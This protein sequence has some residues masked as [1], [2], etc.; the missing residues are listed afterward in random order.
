MLKYRMARLKAFRLIRVWAYALVLASPLPGC[1][2]M[3]SLPSGEPPLQAPDG[4]VVE[5]VDLSVRLT[6]NPVPGASTYLVSWDEGSTATPGSA[7]HATTT[8]TSYLLTGLASEQTYAYVIQAANGR[9]DAGYPSSVVTATPST[10]LPGAPQRVQATAG[11]GLVTL[12]WEPVAGALTYRVS[13]SSKDGNQTL[14]DVALPKALHTSLRNG[15][16]YSYTVRAINGIDRNGVDRVG[17]PSDPVDAK[18]M[19]TQPGVPVI[20]D[21]TVGLENGAAGLSSPFVDLSWTAVDYASEYRVYAKKGLTGTEESLTLRDVPFKA[22]RYTHRGPEIGSMYFY[23]VEAVNDGVPGGRSEEVRAT[24]LPSPLPGAPFPTGLAVEPVGTTSPL[25][26]TALS[27]SA[28]NDIVVC[29][30][31]VSAADSGYRVSWQWQPAPCGPISSGS[32]TV[33][34]N[35][36]LQTGTIQDA[37]YTYTV[38]VNGSAGGTAP[39]VLLGPLAPRTVSAAPSSGGGAV[40]LEWTTSTSTTV[41]EQR[42][43]RGSSAAGPCTLV[44]SFAGNSSTTY[45]D[46]S[47]STGTT[48]YYVLRAFDGTR[49]SMDSDQLSATP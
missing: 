9:G 3:D 38:Q 45:T 33:A 23:S 7:H 26:P 49:E 18:P 10:A 30:S 4:V 36:Y 40:D 11:D 16:T 2:N 14:K 21:V 24:P 46:T 28:T 25:C 32:D 31:P 6:W 37:S 22:T 19:P 43:Y 39:N 17:P 20:I 8:N 47:V 15:V 13:V 5:I 27:G 12:Q 29:W 34:T 42:L 44:T 35:S 1:G 41:A 48:Y